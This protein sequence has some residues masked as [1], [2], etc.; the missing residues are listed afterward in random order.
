[1]QKTHIFCKNRKEICRMGALLVRYNPK[2]DI[3]VDKQKGEI[4]IKDEECYVK[5]GFINEMPMWFDYKDTGFD[6]DEAGERYA[7]KHFEE[8]ETEINQQYSNNE[9]FSNEIQEFSHRLDSG[10]FDCHN[11]NYVGCIMIPIILV[12]YFLYLFA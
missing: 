9:D 1:M 12:L 4:E 8:I 3:A 5:I 6:S 2:F 7:I 10:E 11:Y